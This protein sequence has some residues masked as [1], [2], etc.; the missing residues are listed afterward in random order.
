MFVP[1]NNYAPSN[2]LNQSQN[3]FPNYFPQFNNSN[4]YTINL[5]L[6]KRVMEQDKIIQQYQNQL[7]DFAN[8][9]FII[10]KSKE[11]KQNI[12][13]EFIQLMKPI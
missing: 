10:K 6:C 5:E 9:N 8:S 7:L 11:M 1:N 4:P 3:I 13:K 2:Y 12:R